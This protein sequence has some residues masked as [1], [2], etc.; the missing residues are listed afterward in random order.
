LQHNPHLNA[1][2][3]NNRCFIV[4]KNSK[5]MIAS[6]VEEQGLFQLVVDEEKRPRKG[7]VNNRFIMLFLLMFMKRMKRGKPSGRVK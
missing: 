5:K 4:D 2:L 3:S 6:G 1:I 7:K